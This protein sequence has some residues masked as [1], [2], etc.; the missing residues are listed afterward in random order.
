VLKFDPNNSQLKELISLYDEVYENNIPESIN[1]H[2]ED[3]V[4]DN[5]ED[6]D[7]INRNGVKLIKNK[8]GEYCF[9][10]DEEED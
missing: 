9:E 10:G 2:E 8:D 6:N 4:N 7:E 1:Y 3:N 5:D